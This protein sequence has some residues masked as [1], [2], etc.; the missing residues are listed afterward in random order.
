MTAL[1]FLPPRARVQ[2][3]RRAGASMLKTVQP[4]M[5]SLDQRVLQTGALLRVLWAPVRG[6]C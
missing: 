1:R 6:L 4:A 3:G 5:R 2:A